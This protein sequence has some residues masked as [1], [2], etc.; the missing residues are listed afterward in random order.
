MTSD[1]YVPISLTKA[2]SESLNVFFL[3]P[4]KSREV[5]DNIINNMSKPSL[6]N[7]KLQPDMHLNDLNVLE[8]ALIHLHGFYNVTFTT[9]NNITMGQKYF[10]ILKA[11]KE[12][13]DNF[14]NIYQHGNKNA[15]ISDFERLNIASVVLGILY[16]LFTPRSME[17]Q[18]LHDLYDKYI[19]PAPGYKYATKIYKDL[20]DDHPEIIVPGM[21]SVGYLDKLF[22]TKALLLNS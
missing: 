6:P 4:T 21:T 16:K 12:Y 18:P 20:L 2:T 8:L 1:K 13:F 3:N 9:E 5:F 19:K 10:P 17:I 7:Q 22:I 14:L 11:Y 15:S